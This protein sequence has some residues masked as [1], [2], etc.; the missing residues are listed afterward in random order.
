MKLSVDMKK[1]EF[2]CD[3]QRL[4]QD[5]DALSKHMPVLWEKVLNMETWGDV[6]AIREEV[7]ALARELQVIRL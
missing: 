5:C 6:I 3:M 1:R 4:E 2:L 7:K